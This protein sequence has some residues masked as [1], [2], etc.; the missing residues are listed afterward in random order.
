[1]YRMNH[2]TA[3]KIPKDKEQ[4]THLGEGAGPLSN[5]PQWQTR[6]S[7][8]KE[9]MYAHVLEVCARAG[10]WGGQG[11]SAICWGPLTLTRE[12]AGVCS[13]STRISVG[14]RP[15]SKKPLVNHGSRQRVKATQHQ[16]EWRG[17]LCGHH[18]CKQAPCVPYRGEEGLSVTT[19]NDKR[20]TSF[21]RGGHYQQKVVPNFKPG[22]I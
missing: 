14:K 22:E 2:L 15:L 10:G 12:K 8:R 17:H 20:K 21:S 1:M 13:R 6:E 5:H 4:V 19:V 7:T 18:G 9:E 3:G 16:S 11:V